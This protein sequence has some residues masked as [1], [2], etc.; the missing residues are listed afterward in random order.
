L[1]AAVLSVVALVGS[2]I[3]KIILMHSEKKLL[4]AGE[5]AAV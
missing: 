5:E 4:A 3:W 1:A 2:M